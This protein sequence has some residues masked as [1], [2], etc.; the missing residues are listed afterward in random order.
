MLLGMDKLFPGGINMRFDLPKHLCFLPKILERCIVGIVLL[1]QFCI[2]RL[3][4]F[5][6][7]FSVRT[8]LGE[9]PVCSVELIQFRLM[10]SLV[11]LLGFCEFDTAQIVSDRFQTLVSIPSI[12]ELLQVFHFCSLGIQPRFLFVHDAA[13]L[14]NKSLQRFH[15]GD[16]MLLQES[17]DLA[18]F[19]QIVDLCPLRIRSRIAL[20]E[21]HLQQHD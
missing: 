1:F 16:A 15:T 10:F 6:V 3:D 14:G 21:I 19:L 17:D 7:V 13:S 12:R 2:P 4:G 9:Q 20:V 8:I 5:A 18:E 11:F